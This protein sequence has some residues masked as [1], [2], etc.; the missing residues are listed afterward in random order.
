MIPS[1]EGAP[2]CSQGLE[3]SP[4]PNRGVGKQRPGLWTVTFCHLSGWTPA[5][6]G[7]PPTDPLVNEKSYCGEEPS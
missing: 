4:L 7:Y 2:S 1:P 5:K 6:L 3:F